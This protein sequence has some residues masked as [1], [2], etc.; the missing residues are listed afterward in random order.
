MTVSVPA[1]ASPTT[2][3]REATAGHVSGVMY[4]SV[5]LE[6]I[7]SV[8]IVCP[9]VNTG[10]S[11]AETGGTRHIRFVT[12]AGCNP[13]IDRVARSADVGVDPRSGGPR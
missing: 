1:F 8:E 13:V 7:V 3:A 9:D 4:T 11:A 6:P 10:D 2:L 5:V 12:D